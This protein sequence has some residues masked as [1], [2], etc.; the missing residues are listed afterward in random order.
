MTGA[1]HELLPGA[2]PAVVLGVDGPRRES[3]AEARMFRAWGADVI[4][5][6]MTPEVL[7]A[8]ELGLCFAALITVG[9]YSRDQGREPVVGEVRHGLE[10]AMAALPVLIERAREPRTCACGQ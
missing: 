9:E 6:N 5:L 1:L 7:L 4:S 3:P 8:Q 2:P 10:Q